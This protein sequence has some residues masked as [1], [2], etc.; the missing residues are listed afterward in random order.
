MTRRRAVRVILREI[1]R[2]GLRALAQEIEAR[3]VA[4]RLARMPPATPPFH[5]TPP[6]RKQ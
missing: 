2:F 3:R 1:W 6:G 4:D 5:R